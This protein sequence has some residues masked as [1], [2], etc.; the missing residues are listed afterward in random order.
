MI[1]WPVSASSISATL[2]ARGFARCDRASR[3][4]GPL[5][6]GQKK[7]SVT[8]DIPDESFLKKPEVFVDDLSELPAGVV[9]HLEG[10]EKNR[11]CYAAAG[12]IRLDPYDQGRSILDVLNLAQKALEDSLADRS[13]SAIANEY[14]SYWGGG[15]CSLI[16]S[17]PSGV[18]SWYRVEMGATVFLERKT[19]KSVKS[20]VSA[21]IVKVDGMLTPIKGCVVPSHVKQLSGWWEQNNLNLLLPFKDVKKRLEQGQWIFAKGRNA[22]LGVRL[23][24]AVNVRGRSASSKISKAIL[25]QMPLEH[26][27]ADEADLS[28]ITRRCLGT[29]EHVDS[30]LA[31]RNIAL[32]GCGTIGAHLA[33][34]LVRT[35]A[36]SDGGKLHLIDPE[37]ITP[38]NLGR[39]TCGLHDIGSNKAAVVG[40]QVVRFHSRLNIEV[41]ETGIEH[42][43]HMLKRCQILID[44]TGVE[45]VS[46]W[47]NRQH[48]N[49]GRKRT[50]IY[51]WIVQEGAAVQTFVSRGDHDQPCYRCLR[52]DLSGIWRNSPL[53]DPYRMTEFEYG[54]CGDGAY[55]PFSVATSVVAASLT[56]E[57]LS[58]VQISDTQKNLWTRVT[59]F[60]LS[61]SGSNQDRRIEKA[62]GCPACSE[63]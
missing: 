23:K 48:L 26:A 62:D 16:D 11:I 4:R 5:Q 22:C 58:A 49:E 37:Y 21:I 19:A 44:A 50:V 20:K 18:S 12:T 52:P 29:R 40:E 47:I 13:I 36:G 14:T 42:V 55:V 8:V 57:A 32:I 39:H 3:F 30:S 41:H 6:C 59:N 53:K 7:I 9:P 31:G 35:G 28:F 1:D 17:V 2:R 61:K 24:T 60:K 43:W 33:S 51:S 15:H 56:L 38:A 27:I 46:E 25:E 10:P 34:F 54:T 63:G 45:N